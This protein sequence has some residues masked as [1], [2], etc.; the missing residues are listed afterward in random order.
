MTI[1]LVRGT[2]DILPDEIGLWQHVERVSKALFEAYHYTEIRT[3]IFEHSELFLRA[4]GENS[5]IVNKEMYTFEDKG[6]RSI[7]LRPEGT[8]S[9]ARAYCL[10]RLDRTPH[11]KFYYCGPMFRYERPQAGRYRQFHQIGVEQIGAQ[12]PYHDAEVISL[13]YRLFS[14]LGLSDLTV[15]IN[16]IGDLESRQAI[17]THIKTFLS[18]HL[19]ALSPD[20]QEKAKN[21]PLRLLD[22]KDPKLKT[23]FE[24][25][26][27]ISVARS[28]SSQ[29]YFESVLSILD[30]LGIPYH[31]SPR[32]VRGLDYYSETV[33]EIISDKLGA[34]NTVC[35]GGRYNSLLNEIGR[36]DLPA[37]GFAFGM[38]R[39]LLLLKDMPLERHK[40]PTFYIA[41]VSQEYLTQALKLTDQ[42]RQKE[43]RCMFDYT[44][45]EM[46]A[47]LKRASKRGA[48]YCLIFS[49]ANTVIV[50]NLHKRTQELI[51]LDAL[52]CYCEQI[53][54]DVP[55]V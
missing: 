23:L 7:T 2:K 25:L 26:P 40:K 39:L 22:S 35:G 37:I 12:T 42:L 51:Q 50:K 54:K 19:D 9:V 36:L 5:D 17:E 41:P 52:S 14:A 16:S 49:N 27:D 33:F 13:S 29:R 32:L 45:R 1:S 3:P 28:K 31:I 21:N 43:L 6:G 15:H 34:Q 38:E 46:S 10:N 4:I 20:S 48:D 11:S 53:Q 8:A 24:T 47:H 55:H 30:T 44:A 18:T